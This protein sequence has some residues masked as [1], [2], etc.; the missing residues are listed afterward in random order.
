M[1]RQPTHSLL[2]LRGACRTRTYELNES[3]FTADR[4]CRSA[5][6]PWRVLLDATLGQTGAT[7]R[8]TFCQGLA[9]SEM[10]L[11]HRPDAY[12]A[13]ALTC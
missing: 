12:K 6:T 13:S 2:K 7:G 3:R 5:K 11:N 8:I 1:L 9:C 10:G 4:L